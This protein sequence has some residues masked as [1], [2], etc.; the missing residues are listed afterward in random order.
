MIK[1]TTSQY[2]NTCKNRVKTHILQL[3]IL[4]AFCTFIKGRF[5]HSNVTFQG[6]HF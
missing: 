5:T 4:I 3:T 6:E 2:A 1:P